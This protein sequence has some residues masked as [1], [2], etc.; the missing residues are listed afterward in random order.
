MSRVDQAK[1]PPGVVASGKAA[2][3]RG[4]DRSNG[5]TLG[6]MRKYEAGKRAIL[7]LDLPPHDYLARC[8][9]LADECGV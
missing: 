3:V 6:E 2:V 8:R 9:A 1:T 5:A 4:L 7:D